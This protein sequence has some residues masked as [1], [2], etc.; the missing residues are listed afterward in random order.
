MKDTESLC[1]TRWE[2]KYH[3]AW[4]AKY[5]RKRCTDSFG[6]FLANFCMSYAGKRRPRYKEGICSQTMFMC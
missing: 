6:S 1:H 2:C 4:I 5:R 3:A